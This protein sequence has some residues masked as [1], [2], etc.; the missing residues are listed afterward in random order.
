MIT[1]YKN[2]SNKLL[3]GSCPAISNRQIIKMTAKI[4][5][6]AKVMN[7]TSP[8]DTTESASVNS[9]TDFNAHETL[10]SKLP[11]PRIRYSDKNQKK[12]FIIQQSVDLNLE[13][14]ML[15]EHG[16]KGLASKTLKNH[17]KQSIVLEASRVRLEQKM[18]IWSKYDVVKN[19]GKGSFGEVQMIKN[20]ET[21]ALRALKIIKKTICKASENY[22]EEIEILKRLV[23]VNNN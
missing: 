4:V 22:L 1:I 5:Y 23:H 16:T 20:K 12:Y 8:D 21:K 18:S 10:L 3:M 6:Q 13:E 19:L 9:V 11:H 7:Q 15:S 14:D 17:L 2:Y